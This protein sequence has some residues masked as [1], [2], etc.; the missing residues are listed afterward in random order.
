MNVACAD[1]VPL[2][3]LLAFWLGE[4]AQREEPRL[5]ELRKLGACVFHVELIA[6]RQGEERIVSCH[7]FNHSPWKGSEGIDS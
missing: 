1:P 4:I 5:E 7:T 2:S 3:D 6:Q